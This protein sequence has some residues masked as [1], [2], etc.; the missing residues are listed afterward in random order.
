ME[1]ITL[2]T[3][4]TQIFDSMEHAL[5]MQIQA[6]AERRSARA[7]REQ[8]E[9]KEKLMRAAAS[10]MEIEGMVSGVKGTQDAVRRDQLMT[11]MLAGF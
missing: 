3:A 4:Q 8:R 5:R 9:F 10:K 7:E 6:N 11:M 1:V 2:K